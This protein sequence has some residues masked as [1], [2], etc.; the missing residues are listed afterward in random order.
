[1]EKNISTDETKNSKYFGKNMRK[2]LT[3][4]LLQHRMNDPSFTYDD[5]HA[6]V[7]TFMAAVSFQFVL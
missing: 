6:E 1:M 7:T 2:S 4:I 3:Y 5:L